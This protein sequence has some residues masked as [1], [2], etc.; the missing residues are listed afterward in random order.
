MEGEGVEKTDNRN[1][2]AQGIAADRKFL[3]LVA[4]C[5]IMKSIV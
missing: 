1:L 3:N 5:I 2:L 4:V